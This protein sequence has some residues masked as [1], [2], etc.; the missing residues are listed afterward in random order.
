[1][2]YR[3]NLPTNYDGNDSGNEYYHE[4]NFEKEKWNKRLYET[5]LENCKKRARTKES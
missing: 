4:A 5:T 3:T 2:N 1:M